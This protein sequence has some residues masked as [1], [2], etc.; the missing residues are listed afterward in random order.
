MNPGLKLLF[1]IA[2][3]SILLYTACQKDE[4][5]DLTSL[6]L[7]QTHISVQS[8]ADVHR[9]V[10]EAFIVEDI[11]ARRYDVLG[12]QLITIYLTNYEVNGN[13]L[14]RDPKSRS[15]LKIEVTLKVNDGSEFDVEHDYIFANDHD[16]SVSANIV[17]HENAFTLW[18]RPRGKA[19]L[20]C[21]DDGRICGMLDLRGHTSFQD[22]EEIF[23]KGNF[24]APILP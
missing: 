4:T 16:Y 7:N 19:S 11:Q 2:P 9:N 5:P 21:L 1:L 3:L 15:Q 10:S 6:Y 8:P 24:S 22:S 17:D 13:A 12:E 14:L 18:Y 23:I 20:Y